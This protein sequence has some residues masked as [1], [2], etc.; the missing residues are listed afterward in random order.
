MAG[1]EETGARRSR[2]MGQRAMG[3][4]ILGRIQVT[5]T[6]DNYPVCLHD[7]SRQDSGQGRVRA[8]PPPDVNKAEVREDWSGLIRVEY[9][10][11]N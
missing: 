11:K 10:R 4:R 5:P 2:K 6:W 9:L 1:E 7:L 3:I 8:P